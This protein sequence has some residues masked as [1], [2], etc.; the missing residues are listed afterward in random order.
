[1]F[2]CGK[3]VPVFKEKEVKYVDCPGCGARIDVNPEAAVSFGLSTSKPTSCGGCL[4]IIAIILGIG[5]YLGNQQKIKNINRKLPHPRENQSSTYSP[6]ESEARTKISHI[7]DSL[8]VEEIQEKEKLFSI[9]FSWKEEF[10]SLPDILQ[11]TLMQKQRDYHSYQSKI[12]RDLYLKIFD[13]IKE[14]KFLDKEDFRKIVISFYKQ[15][16]RRRE[17]RLSQANEQNLLKLYEILS[18]YIFQDKNLPQDMPLK[19]AIFQSPNFSSYEQLLCPTA[20][21]SI[22]WDWDIGIHYGITNLKV[23][24][25]SKEKKQLLV[26]EK[27]PSAF[28]IKNEIKYYHRVVLSDGTQ[29][30]WT[31]DKINNSLK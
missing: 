22:Y 27:V 16:Q 18:G 23:S 7:V 5:I 29:A 6:S 25:I 8:V 1:M 15:E 2:F 9:P 31:M 13:Q 17:E 12:A 20:V 3:M 21:H 10:T 4:F 11:N 26:W 14:Q 30:Q 28:K 19:E 24:E